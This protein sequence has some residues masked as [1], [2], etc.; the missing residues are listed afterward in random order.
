[1]L[2]YV[3]ALLNIALRRSGPEDLPDSTF[4]LGLT[5]AFYLVTQ[6]PLALMAYGS[7]EASLRAVAIGL[8][9]LFGGLWALLVLTGHR[10]R[11]RR[12]VTAMLGTSALLSAISLPFSVW[13][14]A[15]AD[16]GSGVAMPSTIIFGIMLWSISI[17]G[18]IVA[19][20]IS[21]PYG[22]GLLIAIAYFF[23]HTMVLFEVVPV[24][25]ADQ[26]G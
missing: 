3:Q 1:M 4:L 19:R 16:I 25:V 20:A 6:A 15:A 18:H 11:Y 14:Q 17:D 23:L 21:R 13:R 8:V 7:S 10:A 9:L 24:G 22:I 5:V 12:A 2:A 26:A